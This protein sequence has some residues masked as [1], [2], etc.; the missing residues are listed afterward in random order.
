MS[1]FKHFTLTERHFIEHALNESQSFKAIG[2]ALSKD[3]T[4]VSKEI[5]NHLIFK[6]T[7]CLGKAFNNCLLKYTCTHSN[8]CSKETCSQKYCRNCE[9]CLKVCHDYQKES[10]P[11]FSNPPYACNG[12]S[13]RIR[14]NLEKTFYSA[15]YAQKEYE[16]FRHESRSGISITEGELTFMDNFV[17]PLLRKGQSIHHICTNNS[18]VIM[19]SEKTIYNYIDSGLF[20]ACNIDLP[21]K[22][23]FRP[24]KKS[25]VLFKVDK[26]CRV[27][28]TY[29]D[30]LS[31]MLENP[32]TSV[33]E[34][35]SVEGVKGGKVLLTIHFTLNQLM[36]AFIRETNTSRSVTNVFNLLFEDIGPEAFKELFPV[37]LT[38]NGSEFSNPAAI[39]F[40]SDGC[41]RTRVFF[42]NPSAPYQKG[43]VE[44]NHSLIRRIIPKGIS[45]N[46]YS[47][48]DILMMMSHINS[49]GRKKLNDHSPYEAF[50]FL[51]GSDLLEKLGIEPILPNEVVLRPSLLKK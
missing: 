10:C 43:A 6:R 40:D 9:F 41:R 30:F 12:C 25:T 1:N 3:C 16:L 39:E 33:V 17:S 51:H 11:N 20:D 34:M 7:G 35:D 5:K 31:Y 48:V 23:R 2:R 44:N 13:R 28:R 18:D 45:L 14:C 32:D 37:I 15:S 4:S 42:C 19:C 50:S 21:R 46:P 8:L 22:V 47:Q 27:G 26:K 49:Y 29:D 38:D 24:R 36:L